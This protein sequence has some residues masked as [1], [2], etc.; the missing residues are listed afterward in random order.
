MEIQ[1]SRT[2]ARV[3]VGGEPIL[4]GDQ[5]RS[6]WDRVLAARGLAALARRA[7]RRH[8]RPLRVAG[9]DRGL[10]RPPTKRRADRLAADRRPLR[11]AGAAGPSPVVELNRAVAFAMAFGAAAGLAVTDELLAEPSLANYHLL[12]SV[13]GD[14]LERLGRREQ[15][16]GEFVRAAALTRN[17]RTRAAAR[18][19]RRLRALKRGPRSRPAPRSSRARRAGW[20]ARR[21]GPR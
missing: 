18:A 7:A 4:L 1:A 17:E 19:G 9:R 8:A 13:R 14:L 10:P 20:R 3:G 21:G 16:H 11:S 12:P 15:A 6:R 5:D 2:T